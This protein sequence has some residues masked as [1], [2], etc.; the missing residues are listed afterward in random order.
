MSVQALKTLVTALPAD[1]LRQFAQW[2]EE[3]VANQRDIQLS[4]DMTSGKLNALLE[5]ADADFAAGACTPL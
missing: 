4:A 3:Y 5:E 1:E 2:F